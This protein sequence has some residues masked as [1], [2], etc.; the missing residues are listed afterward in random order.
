MYR[1]HGKSSLPLAVS[2]GHVLSLVHNQVLGAVV[3]AA[4][5]VALQD[6]LDTVGIAHLS[7]ERRTGHV[8]HHGVAAAPWVLG[9]AK[10][11]VLGRRLREPHVTTV[12]TQVAALQRLGNVLLDDDGTSSSVDEPRALL[13]LGDQVLV[14]HSAGLLMQGAVDRNNVTLRD[15]LLEGVYPAAPNLLLLLWREWL[16]VVV[17]QLLAVKW[18]ETA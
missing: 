1:I 6:T 16:V 12:S 13:H 10:W 18:L 11:V 3:M 17:Q 5:E 15:K 14:E 4:T 8:R 9:V 2:L 7:V